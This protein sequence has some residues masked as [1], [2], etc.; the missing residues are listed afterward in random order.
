[1][2]IVMKSGS[3]DLLEPS[4]A[5]KAYN[6][7]ALPLTDY[8]AHKKSLTVSECRQW[9]AVGLTERYRVLENGTN[10]PAAVLVQTRLLY[11]LSADTIGRAV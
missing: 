1:V 10:K 5:V 2:P 9:L 7:I 6:G 11:G 4:G 3:L 8:K